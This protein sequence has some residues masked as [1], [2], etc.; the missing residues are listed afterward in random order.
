MN[1]FA[2]SESILTVM[3]RL[4]SANVNRLVIVN[5]DQK[6]VGIVTVSDFIHVLVL[7]H[8]STAPSNRN[9][10]AASL[11]LTEHN[12]ATDESCK[13]MDPDSPPRWFHVS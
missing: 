2:G 6:V 5:D 13:Y 1:L 7:R 11:S 12:A 10:R 9:I 3:E 4:V 8:S